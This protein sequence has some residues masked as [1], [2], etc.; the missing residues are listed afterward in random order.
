MRRHRP[1]LAMLLL[2]AAA[3]AQS[4]PVP[5]FNL[6]LVQGEVSVQTAGPGLPNAVQR[7][8][9]LVDLSRGSSYG[10]AGLG[11][12]LFQ[13]RAE[14][15]PGYDS[16]I[17]QVAYSAVD[18]TLQNTGLSSLPIGPIS[19]LFDASLAQSLGAGVGGTANTVIGILSASVGSTVQTAGATYQYFTVRDAGGPLRDGLTAAP[20][21]AGGGAGSVLTAT[22]SSFEAALGL[23]GFSLG[24]GEQLRIL[25]SLQ[26][27][28][29]GSGGWGALTDASQSAQL[30]LTVPAGTVVSSVQ[31]LDWITPVPE[32]APAWLWLAGLVALGLAARVR[33]R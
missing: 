26:A 31:P 5:F 4:Q 22:P 27:L 3:A 21:G 16:A 11:P 7:D 2:F 1:C 19:V 30:S 6:G 29:N 18:V 12:G 9:W 13:A 10:R 28:A 8:P 15:L 33:H 23:P 25:F 14:W 17:T 32:P 20:S 24:P